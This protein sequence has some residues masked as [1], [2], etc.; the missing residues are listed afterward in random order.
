MKQGRRYD[1]VLFGATGF[2]GRLTAEYLANHGGAQLQWALAGRDRAKLERL[3]AEVGAGRA[4]V[5][6]ADARD[7]SA[8]DAITGAARVVAT[9]VGPYM[10]YGQKLVASCAE[11]GTDY[12]DLTGE[13]TFMAETIALH[14]ERAAHTGA[15]IV[16][17]CGFDSIPSDL[18]TL[19]LQTAAR[20][21][22]GSPCREVKFLLERIRGGLSGGTYA[23]FL[24]LVEQASR[25]RN[26][27]RLLANPYAL[28]PPGGE[29]GPDGRDLFNAR[30]DGDA[31]S[32]TAPFAMAVSNTRVVRRTNALLGYRYGKDF[33]YSEAIATGRGPGGAIR[34]AAVAAGNGAFFGAATWG[35]TRK[36]LARFLPKPGEGPSKQSRERGEFWVRLVGLDEGFRLAARVGGLGDPGYTQT[37]KMLGESALC[38]ARDVL[39][40]QGGVLTPAS[41][42]GQTLVE[43]LRAAGMTFEVEGA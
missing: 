6:V 21:R 9:T 29:G 42:L 19:L 11:Q 18:G 37:A 1:V 17:A 10:L 13:V 7:R 3:R 5:L 27:R 31:G 26:L 38:L 20:E 2:V 15:R 39:D 30:Y 36:L 35:P 4:D 12:C 41:C 33:R 28:N 32:W 43:R 24:T 34:A 25:D 40:V 16:H 8:L 23:S 22:R 14:H